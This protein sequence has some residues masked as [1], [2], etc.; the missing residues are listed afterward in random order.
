MFNIDLK[1]VHVPGKLKDVA[2][3]LFRWFINK[4]QFSEAE[5]QVDP[6]VRV[7]VSTTLLYTDKN[8]QYF[9][10]V[11]LFLFVFTAS[12]PVEW[13][14]TGEL[15]YAFSDSTK[16]AHATFFRIFVASAVFMN[17]TIPQVTVLNLL[18]FWN[19]CISM[20]LN[21]YI[22]QITYLPPKHSSFYVAYLLS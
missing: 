20:G 15:S 3:L 5:N 14:L 19:V 1:V 10:C 22:W 8:T 4:Y 11:Y 7:P 6:V 18:C 17:L 13:Q 9:L 16:K 21:T 2:D 12:Q